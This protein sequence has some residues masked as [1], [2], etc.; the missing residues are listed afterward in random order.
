MTPES[1]HASLRIIDAHG[2]VLETLLDGIVP[3][4]EHTVE[5]RSENTPAGVYL[6]ELRAGD[7]RTARKLVVSR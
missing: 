6:Y 4:G 7:A 5:W 1:G 2:R 3:C